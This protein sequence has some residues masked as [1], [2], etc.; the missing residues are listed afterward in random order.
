M[1]KSYPDTD[2][3]W[4]TE[5]RKWIRQNQNDFYRKEVEHLRKWYERDFSKMTHRQYL[6]QIYKHCWDGNWQPLYDLFDVEDREFFDAIDAM[7][8]R[9]TK[10]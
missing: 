1:L 7:K 6:F 5:K 9:R 2:M 4:D 3:V 8:N 10:I